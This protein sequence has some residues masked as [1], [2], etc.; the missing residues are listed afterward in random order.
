MNRENRFVSSTNTTYV[1][2]RGYYWIKLI[3]F[4][5]WQQPTTTKQSSKQLEEI[6]KR[7]W[8]SK[9]QFF[10]QFFKVN[11]FLFTIGICLVLLF[12]LTFFIQNFTEENIQYVFL[13]CCFEFKESKRILFKDSLSFWIKLVQ[14]GKSEVYQVRKK[15]YTPEYSPSFFVLL[16][17]FC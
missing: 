3:I 12:L 8:H 13:F 9:K 6:V 15:N 10:H 17:R 4:V 7:H 11:F 1:C 5:S 14:E 2:L 16:L